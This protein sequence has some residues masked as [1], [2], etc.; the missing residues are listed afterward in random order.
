MRQDLPTLNA[1]NRTLNWT[2]ICEVKITEKKLN[3]EEV[4]YYGKI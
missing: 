3:K 1:P 4:Y 2:S